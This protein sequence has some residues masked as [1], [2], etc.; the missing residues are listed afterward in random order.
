MDEYLLA[1]LKGKEAPEAQ[2]VDAATQVDAA[3]FIEGSSLTV[4]GAA[5]QKRVG[6]AVLKAGGGVL[7][8]RLE[9]QDAAVKDG[10][11]S[12][13]TDAELDQT[14]VQPFLYDIESGFPFLFVDSLSLQPKVERS[15]A[16]KMEM[17]ITVSGRWRPQ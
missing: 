17:H 2:S 6:D 11:L 5:L 14:D 13:S 15:D 16:S 9:L 7:S 8:T 3:P 10:Y 1:K 12:L 4:A